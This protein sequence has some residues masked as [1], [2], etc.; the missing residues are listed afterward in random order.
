MTKLSFK[1]ENKISFTSGH[2]SINNLNMYYEVHG[3]GFPLVLI[4]GGGST[5]ETNFGRIIPLLAKN[6]QLVCV[7][8]Q[9][10]G[11]TGDRDTGLSF[12][13]DADDVAGL[14]DYLKIPKA[15]ILGFSNGGQ[16]AIEIVARHP[17]IVN[18]LILASTFYNRSAVVPQFWEMFNN[19]TLEL[20]PPLLQTGFLAV[21]NNPA[22]LLNMFNRDVQRMKN[23]KDFDEEK[24]RS[25]KSPTLIINAN[26]DV[27]SVEHAVEMHR[28]IPGSELVIFPGG[29]GTY[30][31]AV[32]ALENGKWPAFN[33]TSLIEE[34]LDK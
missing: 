30:L 8:L 2:A 12:E 7:E 20:M 1:T 5:I 10:H 22:L 9:A 17:Q 25:I 13:Q 28:M 34:F 16:T 6:R 31:G 32:E 23:F 21:N 33:A 26:Q 27:G 15:D 3:Q 18:C 24:I 11:R 4:H 19:A 14:L 29:H